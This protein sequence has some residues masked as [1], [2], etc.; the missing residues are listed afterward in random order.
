MTPRITSF[1]GVHVCVYSREHMPPH[2]HVLY[3]DDEAI[4]RISDSS[5]LQGSLEKSKLRLVRKWMKNPNIKIE[6][7][8][9]F[10]ALNPQLKRSKYL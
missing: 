8:I 1:N 6:L 10:F 2:I 3:G 9:Y 7:E 5:L 4:I